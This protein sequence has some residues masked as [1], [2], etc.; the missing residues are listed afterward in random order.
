MTKSYAL[1]TAAVLGVLIAPHGAYAED[2]GTTTP[3]ETYQDKIKEVRAERHDKVEAAREQ[4]KKKVEAAKEAHQ[5]KVDAAKEAHKERVDK[6]LNA[7][8]D[9]IEQRQEN[10]QNAKDKIQ[11]RLDSR[12]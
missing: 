9:R 10:L 4:H 12:P 11:G 1:L 6:R 5:E 2:A 7:K 3:T 8:I